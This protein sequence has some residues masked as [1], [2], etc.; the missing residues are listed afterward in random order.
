MKHGT[1]AARHWR[2]TSRAHAMSNGRAPRP[3]SPPTTTQSSEPSQGRRST[4]SSSGSTD[5][6][7]T[8]DGVAA[9]KGRRSSARR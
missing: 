1:P 8:A 3:D 2:K 9:S 4:D 6:Q 7:R 5:A